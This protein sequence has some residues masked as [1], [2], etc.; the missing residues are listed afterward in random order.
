LSRHFRSDKMRRMKKNIHPKYYEKAKIK[1]ACGHI[2]EVGAS[3]EKLEVEICSQCHPFYT[4][5]EKLIDTAGRVEKF[6]QRMRKAG[7]AS[8]KIKKPR[9]VKAVPEVKAKKSAPKKAAKKKSAK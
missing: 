7:E 3:K 1:C 5:Q 8:K 6:K 4:G 9:K 2:F